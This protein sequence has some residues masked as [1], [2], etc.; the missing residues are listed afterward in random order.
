MSSSSLPATGRAVTVPSYGGA[1]ELR[2]TEVP[3]PSPGPGQV[4]LRVHAAGVNPVDWKIRAGLLKEFIPV[5]LPYTPGGEAAGEVVAVGEGVS[6]WAAGDEVFGPVAGGYADHTLA[7]ADR[8]ATKPADLSWEA[9]AGLYSSAETAN[10]VLDLLKVTEG[11][12]LLVHGAAG[13]VGGLVVQ[14]A[15]ASGIRVVGTA[16]EAN[17]EYLRALGAVPVAYGE[18]VFERVRQ[19]A[20]EGVDAVLDA[21]GGSLA[22][23]VELLGGPE[24]VIGIVS[25]PETIETGT[26]F[27]GGG[28]GENHGA[29]AVARALALHSAGTLDLPIRAV[30]PLTDAAGAHRLSEEGHGRG[31][32]VLVP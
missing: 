8:L 5:A 22:G 23:S 29:Q 9:A 24:R 1:E 13:S 19:A 25:V 27:T 4:L 2:L 16:S 21:A 32:I 17:H 28:E 15:V 14:F 3:V 26:R 31:K 10:R 20:P 7:E 11:E 18:G 12:T 6:A 30:F